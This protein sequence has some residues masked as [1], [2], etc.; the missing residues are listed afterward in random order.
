MSKHHAPTRSLH[1]VNVTSVFLQEVVHY[2]PMV[3]KK[4]TPLN[5]KHMESSGGFT[6]NE[7]PER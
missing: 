1:T 6:S 4:K 2:A 7:T 5:G 3:V